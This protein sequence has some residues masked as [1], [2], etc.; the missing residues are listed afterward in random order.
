MFSGGAKI[1]HAVMPVVFGGAVTVTAVFTIIRSG[2]GVQGSP[3]LWVGVVGMGLSAILIAANTP[4]PHPP[5]K[6]TDNTEAVQPE[7]SSAD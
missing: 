2:D 3:L 4:H 1:P 7:K 6:S 5:K